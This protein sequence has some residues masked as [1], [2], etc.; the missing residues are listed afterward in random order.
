MVADQGEGSSLWGNPLV[1]AAV[2]ERVA[3]LRSGR[4]ARALEATDA[5]HD[6][7]LRVRGLWNDPLSKMTFL[8]EQ[9]GDDCDWYVRRRVDLLKGRR[10]QRLIA[11]SRQSTRACRT[12]AEITTLLG[13][14]FPDGALT[15]CRALF[16]LD[17]VS[18]LLKMH[19][20]SLSERYMAHAEYR[21]LIYLQR[22]LSKSPVEP[23]LEDIDPKAAQVKIDA[24]IGRFDESMMSDWG[25]AKQLAQDLYPE[26]TNFTKFQP[27]FWHVAKLAGLSDR[28]DSDYGFTSDFTH[29]SS[30]GATLS[31]GQDVT[32]NDP[33]D[34]PRHSLVGL[35]QAGGGASQSFCFVLTSLLMSHLSEPDVLS[36]WASA[37]EA[38]EGPVRALALQELAKDAA[39]AFTRVAEHI[40]Q[41]PEL[42]ID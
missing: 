20:E 38:F 37:R 40:K 13:S 42:L 23:S 29:A 17:A 25:W 12:M 22:E 16:E 31:L 14:G 4:A 27:A 32:D 24:I 8:L 18:R 10:D 21:S 41:H 34:L 30:L 3:E 11:L 26:R 36:S 1:V 2:G 35:D 9:G 33:F 5:T 15:G 7:Q 6:V 19:D 39:M 28:Y